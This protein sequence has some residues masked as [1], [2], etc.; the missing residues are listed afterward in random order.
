MLLLLPPSLIAS[1]RVLPPR[2][3]SLFIALFPALSLCPLQRA[4][5]PSD[6][7]LAELVKS[8]DENND[9]LIQLRE[10]L[11]L[12]TRGIDNKFAV[13]SQ[14]VNNCYAAFGG[15]PKD[16]NS[17]VTAEHIREQMLEMFDL[18]FDCFE[19]FGTPRGTDVSKSDF[20]TLLVAQPKASTV[21][22]QPKASANRTASFK[23][24]DAAE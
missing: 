1:Y 8:V 9:G 24:V 22:A 18:D 11:L 5:D 19:A 13:G 2:A 3:R 20:E 6:A 21:G 17:H 7:E 4:Q 14:D 23:K 16:V 15:D 12:Y 10:F